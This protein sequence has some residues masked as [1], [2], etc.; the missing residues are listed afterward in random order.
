M[1]PVVR[2][3]DDVY[4]VMYTIILERHLIYLM[5][6]HLKEL[7]DVFPISTGVE[8]L[9]DSAVFVTPTVF[10]SSIEEGAFGLADVARV[11]TGACKLVY[12]S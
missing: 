1:E 8:V 11:A 6:V 10:S 9:P 2:T 4:L 5:S 12:D 7:N 3:V